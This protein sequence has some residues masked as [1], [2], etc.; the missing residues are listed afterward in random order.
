MDAV[1]YERALADV[2]HAELKQAATAVLD[3]ALTAVDWALTASDIAD[4]ATMAAGAP[5]IAAKL[6]KQGAKTAIRQ[7][8]KA[9]RKLAKETAS[10][11]KAAK[12]QLTTV[13]RKGSAGGER[14]G[15]DFLPSGK[16]TIENENRARHGGKLVCENCGV[17]TVKAEKSR[18]GVTPP[19][20]EKSND[21]IIARANNGDGVPGNGQILCRTCNRAKSDK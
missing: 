12:D 11:V 2:R 6:T 19:R 13:R 21:H 16:V 15:L 9:V 7:S 10:Q 20:N 5:G 1:A 18:K 4:G 17:E 3:L 14:A 8:I